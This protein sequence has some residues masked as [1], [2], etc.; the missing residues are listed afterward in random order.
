MERILYGDAACVKLHQ[1][2]LTKQIQHC[3]PQTGVNYFE[4]RKARGRR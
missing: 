1:L 2:T 4:F 3:K